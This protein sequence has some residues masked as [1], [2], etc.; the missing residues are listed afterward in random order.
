MRLHLHNAHVDTNE[1][2]Q[3]WE[4]ERGM[5]A[6]EAYRRA[7]AGVS[8]ETRAPLKDWSEL[9][10]EIQRVWVTVADEICR[11]FGAIS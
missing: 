6:Y 4:L 7:C 9:G 10:D 5:L 8:L 11:R 2:P 3:A 1:I